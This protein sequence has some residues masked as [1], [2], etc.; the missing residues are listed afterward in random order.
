[1]ENKGV[2]MKFT[3]NKDEYKPSG[4]NLGYLGTIGGKLSFDVALDGKTLQTMELTIRRIAIFKSEQKTWIKF[5]GK[6][7]KTPEGTWSK[8]VEYFYYD[9]NDLNTQIRDFIS[10]EVSKFISED[11]M[12]F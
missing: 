4:K 9:F 6:N 8:E 10:E 7:K 5:D 12:P 2:K 1:L 3:V 11:E